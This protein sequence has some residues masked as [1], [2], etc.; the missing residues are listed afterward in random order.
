MP[1]DA[2]PRAHGILARAETSTRL[3]E[4]LDNFRPTC[5]GGGDEQTYG[6]ITLDGMETLISRMPHQ[7]ALR[8]RD[9]VFMDIGS[10]FGQLPLFVRAA[11][12]VTSVGIETNVCRHEVATLRHSAVRSAVPSGLSYLHA[13]VRT[14]GLLNATHIFMHSTCFGNALTKEILALAARKDSRVRCI[15]DAGHDDISPLVAQWSRVCMCS[16]GACYIR[17]G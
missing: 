5:F 3:H 14:V 2:R 7:C 9:S 10:G 4:F 15:L 11:T 12:G 16:Q 8:Q 1:H 13:D 6:G 17:T